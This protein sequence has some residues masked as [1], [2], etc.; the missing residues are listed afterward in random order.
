MITK[1]S[2]EAAYCFFHQKWKVYEK[3]NSS[4]QK[5]EIEI[6]I[7]SYIIQMNKDLYAKIAEGNDSYLLDHTTFAH[8]LSSSVDRLERLLSLS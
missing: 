2:I 4:T 3:S 6:A 7:N 8:D 1:D 5:D